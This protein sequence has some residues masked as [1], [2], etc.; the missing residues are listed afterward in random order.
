MKRLKRM[1]KLKLQNFTLS[2]GIAAFIDSILHP[3]EE[4]ETE[5]QIPGNLPD[6]VV[7]HSEDGDIKL[8]GEGDDV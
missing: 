2:E 1:M 6:Q 7:A 4:L 8:A 3:K 5:N